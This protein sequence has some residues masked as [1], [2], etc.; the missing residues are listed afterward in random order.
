M[1]RTIRFLS[2][3]CV[4]VALVG[5]CSQDAPSSSTSA[6]PTTPTSGGADR[7]PSPAAKLTAACPLLSA[8]E[9]KTLLGGGARTKLTATDEKTDNPNDFTC[10]YGSG[11][12]KPFALTVMSRPN[13]TP[14][15][16]IAAV[17]KN[18]E[19]KSRR[20]PGVGAAAVIY[21]KNGFS[22]LTA[23]KRY[24]GQTRTVIFAAPAVVPG[25]KFIEVTQLVIG[26]V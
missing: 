26:R 10:A 17:A 24:N 8:T 9:L 21:T 15:A 13:V 16:V 20:V 22:V 23:S 7:T 19:V 1:L 4:G 5:G 11:G 6:P 3:M 14:K 18:S 12:K 2:L 25:R